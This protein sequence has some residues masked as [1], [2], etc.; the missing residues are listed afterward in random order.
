MW[1]SQMMLRLCFF[2]QI[3]LVASLALPASQALAQRYQSRVDTGDQPGVIPD[4]G[5]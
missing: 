4:A 3:V 2:I 1:Y 5:R